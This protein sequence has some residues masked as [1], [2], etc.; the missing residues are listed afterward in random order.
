MCADSAQKLKKTL[1]AEDDKSENGL[2][3]KTI[4]EK[5]QLHRL[6]NQCS[7]QIIKIWMSNE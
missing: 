2:D 6:R 5:K 7:C 1:S 3:V 4:I